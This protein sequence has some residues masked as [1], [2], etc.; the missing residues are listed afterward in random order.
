MMIYLQRIVFA[1]CILTWG[2][3]MLYFYQSPHLDAYL[4]PK[5]QSTL[6][7]GGLAC[8]VV[9]L[10]NLITFRVEASCGHDHEC[11]HEHEGG[12][13]HEESDLNPFMA[14]LI[15]L[16]PLLA[17]LSWTTHEIDEAHIAKQSAQDL[18]P[19]SMRFLAD[20]PPFTK[21]TLDETRQKSADGYYQLNLLELFY[22]AGDSELERVFSDLPFETEG[23]LRDETNRNPNGNRMRLYRLFMTCCAADMKTIPMSIE[24]EG[25]LPSYPANTWVKVGGV[26]SY[27][28]IEGV[29][30]PVLKVQRIEE[31]QAPA[32]G[33]MFK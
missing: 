11:G 19:A 31:A 13:D 4:A 21:E 6:L 33:N 12:H 30:Y 32:S 10:F 17:S 29:T 28:H 15:I 24:F 14:I 22:S 8:S 7:V 3:V 5:F 18:D 20:L 23:F 25:E 27:E 26:M 16:V 2:V 1:L 9:A